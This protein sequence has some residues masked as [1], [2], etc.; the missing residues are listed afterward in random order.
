MP[1]DD[2]KAAS[3][4]ASTP[5][6]VPPDR[7][8]D[9]LESSTRTTTEVIGHLRG[10]GRR[11][12]SLESEIGTMNAHLDNMV[13]EQQITNEL[14]REDAETRKDERSQQVEVERDEREW[15]RSLVER[16]FQREETREE[17]ENKLEDGER[18]REEALEDDRRAAMK[19]AGAEAWAIFKQ[20]LGYLVAGIVAWV[21]YI[22]FGVP[23]EAKTPTVYEDASAEAPATQDPGKPE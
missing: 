20:P 9:A 14:L 3:D 12:E 11:V 21:L 6:V 4:G 16:G 15:R 8:L 5:I 23:T 1:S 2:A 13:R 17:R 18:V 19:R 22:N 7:L 10:L